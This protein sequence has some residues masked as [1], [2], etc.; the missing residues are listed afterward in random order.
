MNQSRWQVFDWSANGNVDYQESRYS[1]IL[2][3]ANLHFWS[4]TENCHN[5]WNHNYN[6]QIYIHCLKLHLM[7][8]Y[9]LLTYKILHFSTNGVIFVSYLENYLPIPNKHSIYSS[10]EKD[11]KRQITTSFMEL[12]MKCQSVMNI[13]IKG[14]LRALSSIKCFSFRTKVN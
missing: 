1:S 2:I 5:I 12:L 7:N 6:Y 13:P 11:P 4:R 10:L 14:R 9:L 8:I 3:L